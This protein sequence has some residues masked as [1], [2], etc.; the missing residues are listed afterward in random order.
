MPDKFPPLSAR[1]GQ[2]TLAE[3]DQYR[4]GEA[5]DTFGSTKSKSSSMGID[6]VKLL[7]EWKLSAS[8]PPSSCTHSS[9]PTIPCPSKKKS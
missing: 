1:A 4:Y 9:L 8:L 7:V 5:V 6:E 3:L 2:K